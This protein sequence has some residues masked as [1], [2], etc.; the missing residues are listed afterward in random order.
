MDLR[1]T[2]IGAILVAEFA[3]VGFAVAAI[4]GVE[5][6]LSFAPR[7]ETQLPADGHL[8]EDGPH[9]VF[10]VGAHPTLTVNIGY[11]DLTIR[12]SEAAVDASVSSS[13]SYGMLNA[14]AP[15][16]ARRDG[17]SITIATA[18]EH[19]WS[20]GDNRMVTVLV[21]PRTAVTVP[22]PRCEASARARS[23]SKISTD[24]R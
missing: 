4:R 9:Q 7:Y 1:V 15:I 22:K 12:A 20:T 6:P 24:P 3:I 13:T 18:A 21:P 10:A 17:D 23:R 19:G 5:V 14:T 8:I 2:I 16:T 11:A